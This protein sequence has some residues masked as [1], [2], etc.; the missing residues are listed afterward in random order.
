M[1][2]NDEYLKFLLHYWIDTHTYELI[3]SSKFNQKVMDFLMDSRYVI[4]INL[5]NKKT[6][7]MYVSPPLN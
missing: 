1:T 7:K 4:V 3:K 6:I 5:N 2:E